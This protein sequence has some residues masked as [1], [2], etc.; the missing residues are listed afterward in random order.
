MFGVIFNFNFSA[1]SS[2]PNHPQLDMVDV[3]PRQVRIHFTVSSVAYDPEAYFVI[4]GTSMDTLTSVSD[5]FNYTDSSDLSFLT[6]TNLK[7][8]I[9]VDGLK[10]YQLYY[11]LI[12]ATNSNS[13]INSIIKNFTT[14]ETSE[15]LLL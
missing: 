2:P 14:P 4:Y 13:S 3:Y 12:R 8:T 5:V 11:Y 1:G 9:M 7:Y 6:D 10:S 15:K